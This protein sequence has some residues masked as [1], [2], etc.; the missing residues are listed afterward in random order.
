MREV[1][2]VNDLVY[3]VGCNKFS[4]VAF[5]VK[6]IAGQRIQQVS[7]C[8][9]I[10]PLVTTMFRYSNRK[11]I[12]RKHGSLEKLA[13]IEEI[14]TFATGHRIVDDSIIQHSLLD[15]HI[16]RGYRVAGKHLFTKFRL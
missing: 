7:P 1:G 2:V 12:K 15:Q 16:E 13:D 14:I 5:Q 8:G 4:A 11:H 6:L 9:T 10:N 3:Y